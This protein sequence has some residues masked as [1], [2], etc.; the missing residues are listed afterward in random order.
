MRKMMRRAKLELYEIPEE[1]GDLKEKHWESIGEKK[2]I[3][4]NEIPA[5][6]V[7]G[8]GLVGRFP[9]SVLLY[10]DDDL[11]CILSYNTE[12]KAKKGMKNWEENGMAERH[13]WKEYA[14]T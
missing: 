7:D 11:K 4:L 14:P 10:D 8:N 13:K 12:E 2:E 3:G 1:D 5:V 9:F 6:F